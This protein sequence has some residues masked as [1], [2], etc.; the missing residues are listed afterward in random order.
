MPGV[1]EKENVL[2]L[3]DP[4]FAEKAKRALEG[5]PIQKDDELAWFDDRI[6]SLRD[7]GVF[8]T[9]RVS[10][11]ID[12]R[13]EWIACYVAAE[14][15][16]WLLEKIFS[17]Y[18]IEGDWVI[19]TY[20][21]RLP[22]LFLDD[23]LRELFY[24]FW[25]QTFSPPK[26]LDVRRFLHTALLLAGAFEN[27]ADFI[28]CSPRAVGRYRERTHKLLLDHLPDTVVPTPEQVGVQ[29]ADAGLSAE[30]CHDA[31]WYCFGDF[32]IFSYKPMVYGKHWAFMLVPD[33]VYLAD[34][35]FTIYGIGDRKLSQFNKPYFVGCQA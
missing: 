29:F 1:R 8:E 2:R 9:P 15:R 16:D 19:N 31:W 27:L 21:I 7:R 25:P 13:R 33:A 18:G 10:H 35:D 24:L 23:F 34:P 17:Q 12:I 5:K 26:P 6:E 11:P 32:K 3:E 20:A 22:V 28:G 30:S 14:D 4:D